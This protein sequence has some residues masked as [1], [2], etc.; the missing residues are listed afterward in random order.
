MP[1]QSAEPDRCRLLFPRYRKDEDCEKAKLRVSEQEA[2]FAF[3]EALC[4]GGK[5]RY[6]VETPTDKLYRFTGETKEVSAQTDLTVYDK[7]R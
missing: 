7:T 6:S 1:I 5:F 3:V 4:K 2:R